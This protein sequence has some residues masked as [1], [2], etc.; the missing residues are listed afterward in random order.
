MASR[1][2]QQATRSKR[3]SI[4]GWLIL[5]KPAGM[6]STAALNKVKRLLNAR[7]AGHAG[8]LDP[9]ATGVLPIAFGE[10]TKTVPYVVDSS[11]SYRFTVRWGVE[12]TTDDSEG[13]TVE[14]SAER[15][16]RADI[17]A[18]LDA[19]RGEIEQTPP[20]FSAVKVEGA[21]AYDLARDG[22]AFDLRS[23]LVR[24]DRLDVVDMPDDDTSVF[25]ADC[26][27]GTYVRAIARDLGRALGCYG[28]ICAL[29]R[30]R[31]GG[32]RVEE[33]VTV[34]NVEAAAEQEPGALQALLAP[35]HAALTALPEIRLSQQDAAR[36]RRGQ[37]VL[38]RGRD[39]PVLD[40][41]VFA[42]ARG[43]LVAVGEVAKGA[44]TPTR[45]FNLPDR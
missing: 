39:A 37:S 3:A 2:L 38:L 20:R 36:V 15:P 27:K 35:V 5:D 29:T 45:V 4:N 42:T 40:E 22:E 17:E 33:A 24:V 34:E 31:V 10:A 6:T 41:T 11:K 43:T 26:G 25:E 1:P 14:Q 30:T 28:H 12:T 9:L 7:K 13:E 23:R 16:S 21:R 8:T 44:F 18:E 32:F 19:F